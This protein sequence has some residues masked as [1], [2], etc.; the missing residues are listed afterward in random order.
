MFRDIKE[1][2]ELGIDGVAADGHTRQNGDYYMLNG[3]RMK[4]K[5]SKP[6]LYIHN[7]RKYLNK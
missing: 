4:Q 3:L 1:L 7:G 2:S 6:G 5:P